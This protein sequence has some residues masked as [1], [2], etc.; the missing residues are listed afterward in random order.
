M[1][2]KPRKNMDYKPWTQ[3]DVNE[4]VKLYRHGTKVPEIALAL[5]RKAT[6]VASMLSRLRKS[7][8]DLPR[9]ERKAFAAKLWD[10]KQIPAMPAPHK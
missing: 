5:E 2:K 7:G 9:G 6:N 3:A 1:E 4:L 10:V 8:V